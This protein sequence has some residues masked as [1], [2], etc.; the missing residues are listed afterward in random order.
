MVSIVTKKINGDEYLYLVGSL[1]KGDK[2][3]QKTLKY[4]G[5]KRPIPKS[6]FECMKISAKERDWVL[7]DYDDKLSYQHH[8]KM[9]ECSDTYKKHLESLD[10]VSREKEREKLLSI[11][12]ANSNAIEGSTM[13]AKE[14]HNFLFNDLVPKNHSKKELFMATNLL[15]AWNYLEKNYQEFPTKQHLSELHKRVNRNI[16]EE[17]TLGKYK[18]VQNYIGDVYTTSYLY[19]EERMERLLTWIKKSFRSVDDFEV[20]FQSHA[21]FEIIHPFID[22]NGRVG[23]LLINWLLMMK[24]KMPLAIPDKKRNDYISALGNSQKGKVEAICKFCFRE[25]CK[26]YEFV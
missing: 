4:I 21:Q 14:T 5:K 9:K 25:Y 22:G 17:E 19:T 24:D 20:A 7:N 1:R 16:E 18:K 23:R 11:F 10:K 26:Q 8:Q 3:I 12:I 2:V 6:E 13:S 15:D